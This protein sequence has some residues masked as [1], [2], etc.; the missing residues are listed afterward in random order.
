MLT[1]AVDSSLKRIQVDGFSF[2]LGVYPLESMVPTPGYTVEFEPADTDSDEWDE[3]PDRY[4]FDINISANRLGALLRLLLTLAPGRVFPILDVLGVDA[5]REVDPYLAYEL[6]G[7]EHVIDALRRFETFLLEDGLVGFGVMSENPFMYLFLDEHKILTLRVEVHLREQVEAMLAAFELMPVEELASVDSST[8]E[9]TSVLIAPEDRPD[10]LSPEEIVEYLRDHWLLTLNVDP[11]SNVDDEGN[12]LG[13]TAWRC[14]VRCRM[15]KPTPQTR[16]A[17]VFLLADGLMR[18]EELAL[19]STGEWPDN[20]SK[21]PQRSAP[22]TSTAPKPTRGK[23]TEQPSED[24]ELTERAMVLADRVLAEEVA[25]VLRE[26]AM[27]RSIEQAK[28]ARVLRVRWL[29]G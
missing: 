24:V 13:F 25:K 18:A 4:L 7:I 21:Q 12:D 9:H 19:E 1:C 22:S 10:L 8:H 2:P 27:I 15:E 17:E 5:Y 29:E 23:P 14:L 16:Y 11:E 20:N 3:W 26:P 6:I 28:A